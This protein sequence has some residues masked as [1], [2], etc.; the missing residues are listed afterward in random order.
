MRE[1]NDALRVCA[2]VVVKIVIGI[3]NTIEFKVKILSILLTLRFD[4]KVLR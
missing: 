4:I 2:S 3:L 1:I